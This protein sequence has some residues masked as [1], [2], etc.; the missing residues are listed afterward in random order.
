MYEL[1]RLWNTIACRPQICVHTSIYVHE[2]DHLHIGYR[3][4]NW[5]KLLIELQ[6]LL[7]WLQVRNGIGRS[8]WQKTTNRQKNT[9]TIVYTYVTELGWYTTVW[10]LNTP[11]QFVL[12]DLFR[13]LGR[14]WL[15][16]QN[17]ELKPGREEREESDDSGHL[18]SPFRFKWR[19]MEQE[20]E[21][22]KAQEP[23]RTQSRIRPYFAFPGVLCKDLIGVK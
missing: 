9:T 4:I 7:I 16:R 6:S 21:G 2:I 11:I 17:E 19:T 15:V 14:S 10:S 22:W 12:A 8:S 1:L 3:Q 23:R 20:R 13:S 18:L 5:F